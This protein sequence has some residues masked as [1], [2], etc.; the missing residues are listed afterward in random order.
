MRARAPTIVLEKI[1]SDV[2][3]YG[4]DPGP[5]GSIER[6]E[7]WKMRQADATP[8][9]VIVITPDGDSGSLGFMKIK[10]TKGGLGA[11]LAP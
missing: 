9:E 11:G 1:E 2:P 8:D 5:D 4:E 3:S 10:G 6:K 7:A